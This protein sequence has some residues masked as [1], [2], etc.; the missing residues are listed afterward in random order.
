M[1]QKLAI[2][3]AFYKT[4]DALFEDILEISKNNDNHKK[5]KYYYNQYSLVK[6]INSKIIIDSFI[7]SVYPFKE[8]IENR[9][10]EFFTSNE[11]I[12]DTVDSNDFNF[13]ISLKIMWKTNLSEENKKIRFIYDFKGKML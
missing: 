7:I 1:S 3:K 4:T 5:L 12:K 8:Q 11:F 13:A 9:N 6:E 10:E 2:K